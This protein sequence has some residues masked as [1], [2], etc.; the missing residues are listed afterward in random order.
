MKNN[1][2][3]FL[4]TTLTTCLLTV[5]PV[6]AADMSSANYSIK[7]DVNDSG[8]G[9]SASSNYMVK[10]SIGQP[11][12]I[13]ESSSSNYIALAGFETIPDSDADQILDFMDNCLIDS[14][15]NQRDT[16]ADGYGNICD[17]DFDSNLIV[18]AGDL[19][20]LK[21]KFFTTDPHADLNGD[22]IVN[23][24]DLGILKRFFFKP[25][26]PSGLAP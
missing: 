5:N 16:D 11:T 25:P 19:G 18:N 4:L 12:A 26:G 14:N 13:G 3:V 2:S 10:A 9:A 24:G 21:T 6:S 22:G 1:H 8:G 15:Q 17:P 23:A 7:W 20:Y